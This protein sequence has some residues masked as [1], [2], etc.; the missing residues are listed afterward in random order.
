MST[1]TFGR[2]PAG[3]QPAKHDLSVSDS[4]SALCLCRGAVQRKAVVHRH[5]GGG[6]RRTGWTTQARRQQDNK[7]FHVARP[8][9]DGNSDIVVAW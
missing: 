8:L 5:N 7:C 1:S 6:G 2:T 9:F 3:R 4:A